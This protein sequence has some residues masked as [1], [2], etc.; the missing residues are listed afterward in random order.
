M[1]KHERPPSSEDQ[2]DWPELPESIEAAKE[3]AIDRAKALVGAHETG[4]EEQ[5]AEA[6]EALSQSLH[7]IQEIDGVDA[8]LEH[9]DFLTENHLGNP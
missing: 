8:M 3:I 2:P 9:L 6:E 4:D 5:I 7:D 1:S